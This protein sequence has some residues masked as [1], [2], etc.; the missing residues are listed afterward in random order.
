MA[1]TAD[2]GTHLTRKGFELLAKALAGSEL[3][4]TKIKLGDSMR[5]GRLVEPTRAEQYEFTDLISP[6]DFDLP[7]IDCAFT[8]GG[9]CTIKCRVSNKTL[10]EGF[11]NRELGLFAVDPDTNQ[12]VL[13]CYRNAG[14]YCEFIPA[15]DSS[16]VYDVVLAVVTVVQEATNVTAII[17]TS[18]A[19]VSQ[20]EF[21][22][23][24]DSSTP[25]PNIPQR[26][27]DVTTTTYFWVT[28]ND[29]NLHKITSDNV[30]TLILGGDAA[31]I[32][33]L[34]RRVR[35]TEVNIANLYM[36]L[37]AEREMGLS[38]NLLLVEDFAGDSYVDDYTRKVITTVAGVYG[39]QIESD[40]NILA[41]HWYTIT[42]G[43]QD[44][45]VQVK[46]VA[47]NMGAVVAIFTDK[48]TNTYNLDHAQLMRSTA[49]I[50]DGWAQGSG[51]FRGTRKTFAMKTPWTGLSA[52]TPATL[53]LGTTLD[54]ADSFDVTG[55]GGFTKNGEFTIVTA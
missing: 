34:T 38:P 20:S 44:E 37:S 41:G 46:S 30:R 12:E 7:L 13:Y 31:T 14:N 32:P 52:N 18:L 10:A 36:Q 2:V 55:D 43:V 19:Y 17:D 39:V 28:S 47:K 53:T 48:L 27:S 23:H 42:D 54:N 1:T 8:G 11:Y 33:Q 24:V 3:R 9:T 45:Y 16:T 35:Q 26:K 40:D 51:R 25:H 50:R 22:A 21:S 15:G 6:K 29:N 49:L 5:N 4:Y